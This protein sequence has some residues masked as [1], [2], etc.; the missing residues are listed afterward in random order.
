[1]QIPT[2]LVAPV[3][4]NAPEWLF[5]APQGDEI[6]RTKSFGFMTSFH[7]LVAA[8]WPRGV[9]GVQHAVGAHCAPCVEALAVGS[10]QERGGFAVSHL[11]TIS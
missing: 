4:V 3:D 7:A 2:H 9:G 5:E 8:A 1:M 6:E 11:S 10:S